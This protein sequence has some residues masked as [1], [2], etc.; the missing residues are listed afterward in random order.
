MKYNRMLGS[1]ERILSPPARGRGLKYIT[2]YIAYVPGM[3]PPARGRG[4]KYIMNLALTV[5]F[6]RPLRGGG[7]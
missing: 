4:L 5:G 7:D 1:A 2:F 3:S 6:G